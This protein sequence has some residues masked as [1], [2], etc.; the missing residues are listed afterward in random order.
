MEH[1]TKHV[2]VPTELFDRLNSNQQDNKPTRLQSLDG[3]MSSIMQT[4]SL[5]DYDKAL[6]YQEA[7]N[8]YLSFRKQNRGPVKLDIMDKLTSNTTTPPGKPVVNNEVLERE[9]GAGASKEGGVSHI[10]NSIPKTYQRKAGQI[11]DIILQNSDV[12]GW[13]GNNELVYN[14][15][16][17]KGSN[18]SDLLYDVLKQRGKSLEPLGWGEFFK[19]LARINVPEYLIGNPSRRAMIHE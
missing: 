5:S 15:E 13:N 3:D 4:N 19:G 10:V 7:L 2:V 14:K 9:V 11:L 6:M 18:I 8:K 12:I 16:T 17:I 1:A